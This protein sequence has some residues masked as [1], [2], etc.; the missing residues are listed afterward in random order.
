MSSKLDA[1]LSYA[2]QE[3]RRATQAA[4]IRQQGVESHLRWALEVA[5]EL[6][7]VPLPLVA[8]VAATLLHGDARLVQRL[9][10]TD[11]VYQEGGRNHETH[12][13]EERNDGA[14]NRMGCL[15][16]HHRRHAS[17]CAP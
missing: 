7:R 5:V 4:I 6:L 17:R 9:Y 14:D 10:N 15:R 1:E 12:D 3:Y 8:A 11:T 16:L 2:R 13:Q